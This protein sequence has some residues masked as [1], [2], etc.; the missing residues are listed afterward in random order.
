M[1]HDL[2]NMIYAGSECF[3]VVGCKTCHSK[4]LQEG[5]VSKFFLS[6]WGS[7][8]LV[9]CWHKSK[10]NGSIVTLSCEPAVLGLCGV[11]VVPLEPT[12]L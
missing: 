11:T 3:A 4:S 10:I 1:P 5:A 12:L 7:C 2:S 8:P 6:V 9:Y